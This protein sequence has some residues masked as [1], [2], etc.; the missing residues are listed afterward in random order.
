M[1]SKQGMSPEERNKIMEDVINEEKITGHG[2]REHDKKSK[3][4]KPKKKRSKIR[5]FFK[6]LG[7][8]IMTLIVLGIVALLA[9]YIYIKPTL[10][11]AQTQAYEKMSQIDSNTFMRLE[12]TVIYDSE[13]KKIGE[14]NTSNYKY[15]SIAL[16][17]EYITDG[18]IAVED[19]NFATHNGLDYKAIVRAAKALIENDGAITQGGSTITQQVLK[20]NVIGTDI[21]KWERKMIE[22]FL[23]PEFEKMFTKTEIMEFYC[24]SN[25]YGNGCYGVETASNYYFGK[26]ADDVTLSE[27][28]ILVGISNSP[29]RYDPIDNPEDCLQRR[30]FVLGR[31]LATGEIT[32]EQYDEAKAEELILVL[33][34]EAKVKETYQVSFAIHCGALKLMELDGFDF[35][36]TFKTKEEF[37]EYTK[38]YNTA[39]REKSEKIR[40]GGYTIKTSLDS[41]MQE[42]LQKAVDDALVRYTKKADDGRYEMQGSAT[43]VDNRTGYVT[44]IVG[45]RGTD[46]EYNRAFLSARQPGSSIKPIVVYGPAFDTGRYYPSLV[47]DDKPIKD[48]PKNAGG[49]YRGKI[50]IREAVARSLNTVPYNILQELGPSTGASYLSSLRFDN[51]SY[52]DTYNGSLALGGFTYGTTTFE[53]AKAYATI[54]M[55][56][57]YVDVNCIENMQFQGEAIYSGAY[58]TKEVYTVDTAYMLLDVMKGVVNERYGTAYG[59]N[60]PNTIIAGKTGTT[61]SNKDGW[62]CGTSAYYSLAAWCGYDMPREIPEM[63]GGR[64]PADIFRQAMTEIHKDLPEKDFDKPSTVK[65]LYVDRDGKKTEDNTGRKDLFSVLGEKRVEED[66]RIAAEKAAK[67]KEE[68]RLKQQETYTKQANTAIKELSRMEIESK[69]DVESVDAKYDYV[70]SLLDKIDDKRTVR[71]LEED[72]EVAYAKANRTDAS[73]EYRYELEEE[74]RKAAELEAERKRKEEE[75]KREEKLK[76]EALKEQQRQQEELLKAQNKGRILAEVNAVLAELRNWKTTEK[77][78]NTLIKEANNVVMKAIDYPEYDKLNKEKNELVGDILSYYNNLPYMSN[79]DISIKHDAPTVDMYG[80]ENNKTQEKEGEDVEQQPTLSETINNEGV[81]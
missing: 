50:T 47:M 76:E 24:N 3:E 2:K 9:G 70:S 34:R 13:G 33:E 56:G 73:G 36:Y 21:D 23:A 79:P 16:I 43:I 1:R 62:F 63:G 81:Q 72:L 66:A 46:D 30:D 14:I 64:F 67:E 45:G 60:I 48:G 7:V 19:N 49:G 12:D 71:E 18:Y 27:A 40:N 11:K 31:M 35:K 22:F 32:Q 53:M 10:D 25:F 29:S 26:S 44:A 58:K 51:L 61:N 65:E 37:E 55:G 38:Q 6:G 8:F 77:D 28:A 20:N 41:E 69:S 52:L 68:M 39:Y 42:V 78:L 15:A 74:K 57:K 75:R 59:I 17:S 4:E 54:A 80:N 5:L